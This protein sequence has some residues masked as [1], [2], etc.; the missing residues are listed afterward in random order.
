[1]RT[2]SWTPFLSSCWQRKADEQRSRFYLYANVIN[3][4]DLQVN[5]SFLMESDWFPVYPACWTPWLNITVGI[6]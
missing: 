1:M 3:K 2:G 4:D 5:S 6:N